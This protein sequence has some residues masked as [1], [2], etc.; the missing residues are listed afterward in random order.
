[1]LKVCDATIL[2]DPVSSLSVIVDRIDDVRM[3]LMKTEPSGRTD[4]RS[5]MGM[6]ILRKIVLFF[7]PLTCA[8]SMMP[9]SIARMPERMTSEVKAP[10]AMDMAMTPVVKAS[11]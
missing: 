2:A 1:G 10:P 7:S 9:G 5:A 8:A 4:V 3:R 6:T 11:M